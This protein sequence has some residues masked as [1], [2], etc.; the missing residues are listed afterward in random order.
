MA[1]VVFTGF[2]ALADLAD[3]TDFSAFFMQRESFFRTEREARKV[4]TPKVEFNCDAGG[5][6]RVED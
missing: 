4:V 1:A 6:S 5:N 2:A 3:F